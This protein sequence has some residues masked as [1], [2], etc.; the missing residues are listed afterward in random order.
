MSEAFRKVEEYVALYAKKHNITYEEA[1]ETAM[2][3]AFEL[4]HRKEVSH[5]GES[6]E[7]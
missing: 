7:E 3:K 6:K 1:S 2:C 5:G 4:L